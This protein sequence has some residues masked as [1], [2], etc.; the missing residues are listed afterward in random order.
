M[1]YCPYQCINCGYVEDNGWISRY[2]NGNMISKSIKCSNFEKRTEIKGN[3]SQEF[4]HDVCNK[5]YKLVRRDPF[6]D[7]KRTKEE[8]KLFYQKNDF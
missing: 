1:G 2:S 4:S 7:I 6:F 3:Y 5:C 8:R